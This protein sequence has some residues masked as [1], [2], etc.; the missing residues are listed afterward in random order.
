MFQQSI[1]TGVLTQEHL[2]SGLRLIEY[3]DHLLELKQNH[4]H[5]AFFSATG[6]RVKEI[7]QLADKYV[8][9]EK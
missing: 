4:K 8:G 9:G 5:I 7:R 2:A 3:D 6:A 1:L